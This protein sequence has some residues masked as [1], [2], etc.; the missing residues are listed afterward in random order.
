M[1]GLSHRHKEGELRP[2]N[3]EGFVGFQLAG[4]NEALWGELRPKLILKIKELVDGI[5]EEDETRGWLK[6]RAKEFGSLAI[7]YAKS[8]LRREGVEIQKIEAEIAKLF[9]EAEAAHEKARKDRAD[10][11]AVEFTTTVKE[12]RLALGLTKAMMMGD[13]GEESILFGKQIDAMLEALKIVAEM[14]I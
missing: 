10:A 5:G 7:D 8:K 1:G 14:K 3:K 11:R 2:P 6:E 13:E 4:K 9:S 12:L